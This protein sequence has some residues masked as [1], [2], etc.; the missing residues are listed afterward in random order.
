MKIVIQ[1]NFS[2]GLGDLYCACTEYLNFIK[3]YKEAGYETELQFCFNSSSFSNKYIGYCD[4][5]E[6]FDISSFYIFDKITTKRYSTCDLILNGAKYIHTQ[7]GPKTPGVHFWDIFL[8]GDE[9]T[10]PPNVIK[11]PN[12]CPT[13]FLKDKF[14]PEIRPIFNSEVYK[15]YNIFKNSIPTN[16]HSVQFRYYDFCNLLNEPLISSLNIFQDKIS[17]S[18]NSYHL[19][20]NNQYFLNTLSKLDNVFTYKFKNLDV[21]TNDHSY[22][23]YN[24]GIKKELL[25]DRIYDNLA[26]M[27]SFKDS[28]TITHFSVLNWVSNFLYYSFINS[29][30][31]IDF[32]NIGSNLDELKLWNI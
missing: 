27:I 31:D 29:D 5:E 21:F 28:Q 20:S 25:L 12:Y 16:H 10:I 30:K 7:Y 19:G 1:H 18:K 17:N 4:F 8:D 23:Y 22:F 6:L 26:E 24:K 3:K 15:R 11:Y 9:I 14:K 13:S 2:T 32:I